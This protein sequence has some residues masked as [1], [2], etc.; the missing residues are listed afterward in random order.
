MTQIHH[1]PLFGSAEKRSRERAERRARAYQKA[2]QEHREAMSLTVGGKPLPPSERA[3]IRRE[4]GC[5]LHA[6]TWF[7]VYPWKR[8][9]V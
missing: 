4:V 8:G 2:L 7:H 1:G 5:A 3:R 6:A 9:P